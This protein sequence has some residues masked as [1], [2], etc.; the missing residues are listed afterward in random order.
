L[1][2]WLQVYVRRGLVWRRLRKIDP[3]S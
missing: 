3:A 1:P 2:C